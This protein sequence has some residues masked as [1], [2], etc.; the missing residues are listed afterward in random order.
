M[1]ESAILKFFEDTGSHYKFHSTNA[2]SL[3]T[4]ISEERVRKACGNSKVIER[5]SKEKES[6]CLK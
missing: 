5:N 1:D 6:W 2:I 3:G 4:D